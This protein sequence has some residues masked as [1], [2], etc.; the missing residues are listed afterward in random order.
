MN[1]SR[2]EIDLSDLHRIKEALEQS[3]A[4]FNARDEMNAVVHLDAVRYSPLTRK[5]AA[6]LKQVNLILDTRERR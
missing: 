5:V 4:F 6:E 3:L 1:A 2:I